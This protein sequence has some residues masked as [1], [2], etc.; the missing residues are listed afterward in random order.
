VRVTNVAAKTLGALALIVRALVYGALATVLLVVGAVL[1]YGFGAGYFEY[2]TVPPPLN[3]VVAP[4]LFVG[5][6]VV[7]Y[8]FVAHRI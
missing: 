7:V 3:F 6:I 5:W 8:K 2:F 1:I 4:A